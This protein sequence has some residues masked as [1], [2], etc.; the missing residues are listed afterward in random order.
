MRKIAIIIAIAAVAALGG[1]KALIEENIRGSKVNVLFP[2]T[3]DSLNTYTVTFWWDQVPDATTYELQLV[4][5]TFDNIQNFIVD[6]TMTTNRYTYILTPGTYQW[7]VRAL[8]NSTQ[9]DFA[10]QSFVVLRNDSLGAQTVILQYPSDNLF[11]NQTTQTFRWY[12]ISQTTYYTFQL[13]TSA[14]GLLYTAD[15][16]ADSITV[17]SIQ[18]GELQWRVR[19]SNNSSS[20]AFTARALTIDSVAPYAPVLVGPAYGDSVTTPFTIT[21]DRGIVSGSSIVDSVYLYSDS[22][23]TLYQQ[24]SSASTSYS[25]SSMPIGTYFW[26]VRSR[27]QA[28][29]SSPYS[30]VGKFRV[31]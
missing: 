18:Q 26:R 21:W 29:N 20:T 31:H 8:N 16:V 3:G 5:G 25:V 4:Q 19:A 30:S 7:R 14:G 10:T 22:L 27:D 9:T 6:S 24:V 23:V 13:L 17:S 12:P 28:G 2:K 1:C 11:S 15:L